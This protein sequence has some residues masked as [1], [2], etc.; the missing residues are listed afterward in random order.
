M[1][2]SR[3]DENEAEPVVNGLTEEDSGPLVATVP[4]GWLRPLFMVVVPL[5]AIFFGAGRETWSQGLA[6]GL[7]GAALVLAP[8]KRRLPLAGVLALLAVLLA[9]LT[10][11]LPV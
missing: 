1:E 10:G 5:V 3:T 9:P 8:P 11:F 2:S 7:A 4:G 6:V